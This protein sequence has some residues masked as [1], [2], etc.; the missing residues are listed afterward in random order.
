[1]IYSFSY[2][3]NIKIEH[4]AEKLSNVKSFFNF[5][6]EKES[7]N[8]K[9]FLD[10]LLINPKITEL[11]KST[12]NRLKKMILYI[13]ILTTTKLKKTSWLVF[14]YMPLEYVVPNN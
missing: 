11:F 5:T 7:N 10:I 13:F 6:Y 9:P 12:A 1:M 2:L 4:I 3:Q 8:T 14:I